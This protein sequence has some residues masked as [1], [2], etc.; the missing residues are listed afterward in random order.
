M[1]IRELICELNKIANKE[2]EVMVPEDDMAMVPCDTIVA[3]DE[4]GNPIYMNREVLLTHEE[5]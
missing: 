2:R 4:S 1:T 3:D 5:E